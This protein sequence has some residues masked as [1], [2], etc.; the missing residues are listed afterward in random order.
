MPPKKE[1]LHLEEA[2]SRPSSNL[3]GLRHRQKSKEPEAT[4]LA[5]DVP[6]ASALDPIVEVVNQVTKDME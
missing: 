1:E 4:A 6:A 5:T 3:R 2:A